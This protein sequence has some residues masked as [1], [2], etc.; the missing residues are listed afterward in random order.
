MFPV[1]MDRSIN[2]PPGAS[3]R[4]W[5][6]QCLV[7]ADQACKPQTYLHVLSLYTSAPTDCGSRVPG[8]E[9]KSFHIKKGW[10]LCHHLDEPL[11]A[12]G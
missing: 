7:T 5:S 4:A 10:F 2:T 8:Y 12:L 11:S 3:M 6:G 1:Y 9:K